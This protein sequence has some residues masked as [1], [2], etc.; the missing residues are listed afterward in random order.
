MT[1][2]NKW[3]QAEILPVIGFMIEIYEMST[4]NERHIKEIVKLVD[5]SDQAARS[6]AIDVCINVYKF[7]GENFWM[8]YKE[9]LNQKSIDMI[10][11]RLKSLGL[12]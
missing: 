2:K 3:T 11:S 8:S 5:S 7:V 9:V 4:V 1:S 10:K 12:L 6:N